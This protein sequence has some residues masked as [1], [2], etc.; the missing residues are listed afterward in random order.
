MTAIMSVANEVP[1][2]NEKN[3]WTK[4]KKIGTVSHKPIG[5]TAVPA[6]NWETDWIDNRNAKKIE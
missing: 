2:S 3:G 6:T 1:G 4:V 5:T